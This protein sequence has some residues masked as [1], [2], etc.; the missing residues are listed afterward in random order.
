MGLFTEQ[1]YPKSEGE[2]IGSGEVQLLSLAE[3]LDLEIVGL[4]CFQV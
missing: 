2:I 3:D 1:L 4:G